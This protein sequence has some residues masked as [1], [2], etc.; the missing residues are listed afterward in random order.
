MGKSNFRRTKRSDGSVLAT[1]AENMAAFDALPRA[2]QHELRYSI[3]DIGC[4]HLL[5]AIEWDDDEQAAVWDILSD[6]RASEGRLGRA[7]PINPVRPVK[8]SIQDRRA[9]R[10]AHRRIRMIG[11]SRRR[12]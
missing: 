6:I 9:A 7:R 8:P 2:L 12:A 10:L 3:L 5:E 11:M 1:S 4:M